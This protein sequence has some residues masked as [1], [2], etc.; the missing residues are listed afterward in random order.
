[1]GDGDEESIQPTL[2]VIAF[3]LQEAASQN[4]LLIGREMS[5]SRFHTLSPPKIPI[6]KY[7]EDLHTMGNCPRSVFVVALILL[8]RLIVQKPEITITPNTVHKLFLCSL[9]T[10]SKFTTDFYYNNLTWANIGGIK[11]EEL[12]LLEKEYLFALGFSIVVTKEEFKM[13]DQELKRK[14]TMYVFQNPSNL[15]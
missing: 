3:T 2:R 1:M 11:L 10:A 15:K 4:K 8:D 14:C 7:L 5:L 9:M 13:Y 6:L 12:N